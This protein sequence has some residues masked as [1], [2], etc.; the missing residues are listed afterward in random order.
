MYYT[1]GN[2]PLPIVVDGCIEEFDEIY[3]IHWPFTPIDTV[4]NQ[5]CGDG[6][7]LGYS[8]L[9]SCSAIMVYVIV[10]IYM[11]DWPLVPAI[12]VEIG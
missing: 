12:Q 4:S 7:I 8:L 2:F 11:Q 3:G 6:N 9:I 1:E 5:S 10:L